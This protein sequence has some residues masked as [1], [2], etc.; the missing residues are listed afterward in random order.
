VLAEECP[1]GPLVGASPD[2]AGCHEPS[3]AG[4]AAEAAPA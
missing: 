2:A 3:A 4:A 1:G